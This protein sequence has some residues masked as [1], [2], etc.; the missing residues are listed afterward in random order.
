M[1]SGSNSTIGDEGC[2]SF[3]FPTEGVGVGTVVDFGAKEVE[4]GSGGERAELGEMQRV[5]G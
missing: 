3:S 2:C 4:L 1:S 5:G